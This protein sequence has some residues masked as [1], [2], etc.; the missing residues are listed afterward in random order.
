MAVHEI[1]FCRKTGTAVAYVTYAE[2]G[3]SP[4]STLSAHTRWNAPIS[5]VDGYKGTFPSECP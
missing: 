5:P 2:S 3:D 1:P 4:D